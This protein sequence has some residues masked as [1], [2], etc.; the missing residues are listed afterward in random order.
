[1]G[2]HSHRPKVAPDFR[3]RLLSLDMFCLSGLLQLSSP[4]QKFF[5]LPLSLS[6]SF[7]TAQ[8]LLCGKPRD[9]KVTNSQP[10]SFVTA[11]GGHSFSSL[12]SI[13]KHRFHSTLFR[14]QSHLLHRKCD[15]PPSSPFI[16]SRS[17]EERLTLL[18]PLPKTFRGPKETFLSP[19]YDG[20][21]FPTEQPDELHPELLAHAAVDDE[22]DRG[23]EDEDEVVDV[24]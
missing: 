12:K 6:R 21:L 11:W 23:V 2:K 16:L 10:S 15:S 5:S 1:M 17:R 13:Q 24:H 3:E 22:V 7:Y 18:A 9:N 14:D 20:I 19:N 8:S 4:R